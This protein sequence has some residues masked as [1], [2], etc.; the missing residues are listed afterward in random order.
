MHPIP[1]RWGNFSREH[2]HG[3]NTCNQN[4][5]TCTGIKLGTAG[6]LADSSIHFTRLGVKSVRNFFCLYSVPKINNLL[7][8]LSILWLH[9]F[10]TQLLLRRS[11]AVTVGTQLHNKWLLHTLN[12]Y[13]LLTTQLNSLLFSH[14]L[15]ICDS[16][17]FITQVLLL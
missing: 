13:L 6:S 11:S 10:V 1:S 9:G 2:N 12:H 4:Y 17:V 5:T 14:S 3:H 16:A 7:T 15:L 8:L